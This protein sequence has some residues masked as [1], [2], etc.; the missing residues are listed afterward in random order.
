MPEQDFLQVCSDPPPLLLQT[1][2]L[3]FTQRF[4]TQGGPSW[5]WFKVVFARRLPS[6]SCVLLLRAEVQNIWRQQAKVGSGNQVRL[7]QH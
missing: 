4:L 1:A 2:E 3:G 6:R 7:C 5:L